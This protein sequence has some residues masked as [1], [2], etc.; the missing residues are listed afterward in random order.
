MLVIL[1]FYD[2]KPNNPNTKCLNQIVF[3]SSIQYRV[4]STSPIKKKN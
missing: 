4:L 2:I 3:A 1:L